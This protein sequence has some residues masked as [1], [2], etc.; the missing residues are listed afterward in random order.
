MKLKFHEKMSGAQ[1]TAHAHPDIIRK[2]GQREEKNVWDMQDLL[3]GDV[4]IVVKAEHGFNS[5]QIWQ[6]HF[7]KKTL[8]DTFF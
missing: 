2:A 7:R 5:L 1:I 6:K 8:N 3:G 4:T